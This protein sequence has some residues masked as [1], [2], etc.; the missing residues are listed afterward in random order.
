MS[1]GAVVRLDQPHDL[2][3]VER[4][5]DC[6]RGSHRAAGN[7]GVYP[8]NGSERGVVTRAEAEGIVAADA[9]G[10]DHV[11]RVATR[12]DCEGMP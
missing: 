2:V 6:W 7:W 5:P 3:V 11:V 8:A 9:D 1:A 4:M 10:Y 12:K